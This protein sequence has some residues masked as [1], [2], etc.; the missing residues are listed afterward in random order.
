M[1]TNK[2]WAAEKLSMERT[3][4][5]LTGR[6]T[7][8][9]DIPPEEDS[10]GYTSKNGY[11]HIAYKHPIIDVLKPTERIIFRKGVF[12]HETGHQLFTDFNSCE[13]ILRKLPAHE[14]QVFMML[15][16]VLEDPAI[17]YCL[18]HEVGGPLLKSLQF[19]IAHIYRSSPKI[20]TSETAFG[21]Y[22]NALIHF[23]DMGLV[24]GRFTFPEAKKC[25]NETA[26]IFE[27]G[28]LEPNPTKRLDYVD[29]IFN[30]SRPLW[31][32]EA[33]FAKMMQ[34]LAEALEEMGKSPMTG[35][36]SGKEGEHSSGK[37]ESSKE[38]RR[39][40]TIKK[41]SKEEMKE[42]EENDEVSS[43]QLPEEGDITVYICD[44][45]EENKDDDKKDNSLPVP[46]KDEDK[47]EEGSSSSTDN[48]DS[49]TTEDAK[50]KNENSSLKKSDS[51]ENNDEN[52]SSKSNSKSSKGDKEESSEE[53]NSS[54]TPEGSSNSSEKAPFDSS[55]NENSSSPGKDSSSCKD[56]TLSKQED[57]TS[58][59]DDRRFA[60]K[61]TGDKPIDIVPSSFGDDDV[62]DDYTVDEEEYHISPEDVASIMDEI[63]RTLEIS[64]E[65]NAEDD[66]EIPNYDVSSSKMPNRRCLNYRVQIGEYEKG[67]LEKAY[68]TTLSKMSRGIHTTTKALKRIFQDDKEEKEYRCSGNISLKRY[69]S[70]S[71]TSQLFEKKISP[72]DKSDL[73]VEILVDESGSMSGNQKYVAARESCIALAEIFNNL[74]IPVYIMGFTADTS[75]VSHYGVVHAHYVTWK[76][77]K[78]DRL[79]LLNISAR[80][81]NCDGA[82]IRYA[83]E[84]LKKKQAKNKLLIVLSD[85]MPAAA[86]YSNG[87]SDTRDAVR[88]A[89][90]HA[91]VLGVAIGRCDAES[92]QYLYEKD[93]LHIS[94]V[95]DLF[96]GI[97]K[98]MKSI[99]KHW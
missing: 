31:Q 28:I 77:T 11:I 51:C 55:D 64:E 53:D 35:S 81:N 62:E 13:R 80:S 2:V 42:M 66:S 87:M 34:D 78:N 58:F 59:D 10:L 33:D 19:Q 79:K 84:V 89:K 90:K 86:N 4:A 26:E 44:E 70:G 25:F 85:G 1:K 17:E 93:F 30:I 47:K 6:T 63:E 52:S 9:I 82:S 65:L 72:A 73:V 14:R 98:Q 22:V 76:N 18:S 41:I 97:S 54:S 21:Q 94:N 69:C 45:E 29:Q 60:D 99:I 61:Q 38:K 96:A 95:E 68:Q 71:V 49:E 43:G 83:T 36:G 67:A 46:N 23:G 8:I 3:Y 88:A 56:S 37:G 74:N 57:N 92:I 16:N 15:A 50:K 75:E 32:E 12:C 7:K 27:K 39:K 5:F 40:I 20:Q 48:S 24:K 91:S